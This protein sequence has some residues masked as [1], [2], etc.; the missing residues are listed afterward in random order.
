MKKL[1]FFAVIIAAITFESCSIFGKLT[2]STTI[3]PQKSFVLGQGKHGS[4]NAKIKNSGKG[5]IE[6]IVV[7]NG[8]VATS[9]G[10]LK[11]N[12]KGEYP[13]A[14]NTEVRFKNLGSDTGEIQILLTGDTN[15]S[16]GY[17]ENK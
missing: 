16:M 9:L 10:V 11:P 5:D 6:V 8:G 3:E 14:S 13:V 4:Y 17:R 1:F 7:K 2:S 15:L 12:E